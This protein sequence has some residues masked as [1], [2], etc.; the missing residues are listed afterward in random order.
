MPGLLTGKNEGV[1]SSTYLFIIFSSKGY[2][3]SKSNETNS[4][5]TSDRF[6]TYKTL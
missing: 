4:V 5:S 3:L 2:Y 6:Y 1:P